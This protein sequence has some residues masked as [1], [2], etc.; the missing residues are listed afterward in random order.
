[1][2][3]GSLLVALALVG[4]LVAGCSSDGNPAPTPAPSASTAATSGGN[5]GASSGTPAYCDAANKLKASM[6]A[7][8]SLSVSSGL[9]GVQTAVDN[10]QASLTEFQAAAQSQFGH[11]VQQ[12]RTALNDA[13]AAIRAAGASPSSSSVTAIGTSAA[14]TV[15]AYSALQKAIST[16]CG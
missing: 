10:I 9:S 4:A 13:T 6:G 8:G 5:G 15:A 11:E 12:L 1:M 3:A 14:A 7:L 16:R 2:S